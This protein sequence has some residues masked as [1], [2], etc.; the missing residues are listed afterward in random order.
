M[1]PFHHAKEFVFEF[2]RVAV[3]DSVR[4]LTE[5]LHLPLAALDHTMTL[6]SV[7]VSTL[8]P[9][10]LKLPSEFLKTFR[11]DSIRD[12]SRCEEIVLTH[13]LGFDN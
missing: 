4:V 13:F 5:D 8:F 2:F 1:A 3:D 6:E 7:L 10:H 12:C 11:F 9:T